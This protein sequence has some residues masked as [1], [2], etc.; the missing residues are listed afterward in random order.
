MTNSQ[1]CDIIIVQKTKGID[2]MITACELCAK[3]AIENALRE[4]ADRAIKMQ[5]AKIFA[6]EIL[7]PIIANLT[8]IPD[9]LLIGYRCSESNDVA[10]YRNIS[11][12]N[13]TTT[14]SGNLRKDRHLTNKVDCDRD[15]STLDYEILNQYLAEFGFQISYPSKF[16]IFT[17]YSSSTRDRGLNIDFLYLSMTCPAEDF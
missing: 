6:E 4:E 15:F 9:H 3:I 11:D 16:T 8:E 10:L 14:L 2:T 5:T 1:K 17:E 12:W 13:E 7:S